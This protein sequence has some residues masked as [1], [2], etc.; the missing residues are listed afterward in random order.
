MGRRFDECFKLSF[1]LQRNN[2][3]PCPPPL[4]P[5]AKKGEKDIYIII[6]V[7]G[8]EKKKEKKY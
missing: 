6:P 7:C 3:R 2:I 5:Y 8:G 1:W 4:K